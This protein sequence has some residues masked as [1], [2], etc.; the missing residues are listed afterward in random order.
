MKLLVRFAAL[1]G[2]VVAATSTFGCFII[3]LDEPEMPESLL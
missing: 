1:V 2:A 3:M